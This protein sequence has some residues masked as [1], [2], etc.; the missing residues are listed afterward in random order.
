MPDYAADNRVVLTLDAGGT[1]FVFGA[2]AGNE[3][4]TPPLTLPARADDLDASLA[5]MVDGFERVRAA[6]PRPPVAISFAFPGPCDYARGIVVAPPNLTAYRN[7]ALGPMLEDRFGLPVF[8]NNDGDLFAVGEAA[9]GLLPE[10]NGM[11]ERAGSPKRFRNLAGFTI[12]TGFGCGIVHQG[13][14]YAGDNSLGGEVWLLRNKLSPGTNVEEGVSIRAVRRAY[15]AF[16]GIA[17]IDAPEPRVIAEIA[18]GETPGDP[19]AAKRAFA[20]LGEVA[21][22]AISFV[23]TLLDA[24]VVIGGGLAAAHR[25]FLP[26]L[27][28]EMNGRYTTPAGEPFRRLVQVAFDLEDPAERETFLRGRT[29]ELTV[30]GSGRTVTF[31]ALQRTGVGISR[32]GTSHATAIGAYAYALSRLPAA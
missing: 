21:G 15:A 16:A 17:A 1:N 27:V 2:M 13:R 5:T 23:T 8:I 4:V 9:A 12:G 3:P 24:L 31:D 19:D 10:V 26:S 14:L 6:A 22:D 7:V 30:P 11:L 18:R 28:A 32:L 20:Q 29:A 25:L